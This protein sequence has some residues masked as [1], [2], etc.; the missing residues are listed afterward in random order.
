MLV[1]SCFFGYNNLM[2]QV[3]PP[4]K[5]EVDGNLRATQK[6]FVGIPITVT[7]DQKI[8]DLLSKAEYLN[9]SLYVN[10]TAMITKLVV[11][12]YEAWPDYVFDSSYNLMP[13]P[14]LQ[15][16]IARNKHLPSIPA[17]AEVEKEGVD[18]ARTQAALLHKIEELTLYILQQEKEINLQ[19][20][21]SNE[22]Q[23]RLEH[24]EKAVKLLLDN[25]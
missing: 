13:L 19:K 3:T 8:T 23:V 21:A 25:K 12:K 5:F 18:V 22:L 7:E 16:Y 9:Y 15:A 1:L 10:G 11:K 24:L 20:K 4:F 14:D 17:A 2:A 6:L